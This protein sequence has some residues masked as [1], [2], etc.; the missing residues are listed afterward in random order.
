MLRT[1][2]RQDVCPER[3]GL[4]SFLNYGAYMTRKVWSHSPPFSSLRAHLMSRLKRANDA[5]V[6]RPWPMTIDR[7]R[8]RRRQTRHPTRANERDR[9]RDRDRD[10]HRDDRRADTIR[11]KFCSPLYCERCPSLHRR[12]ESRGQESGLFGERGPTRQSP[13][14]PCPGA[15]LRICRTRR[16]PASPNRAPRRCLS[17]WTRSASSRTAPCA[18]GLVTIGL[19]LG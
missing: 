13:V 1:F 14:A 3:S 4:F 2:S 6:A 8:A 17:R 12:R 7:A 11:P 18:R 15:A 10:R 9:H 16:S 19:R 5:R